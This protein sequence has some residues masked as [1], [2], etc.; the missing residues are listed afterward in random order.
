M[1]SRRLAFL[2][3]LALTAA[4]SS[5]GGYFG[6]YVGDGGTPTGDGGCPNPL[7]LCGG[8]CTS[9]QFDARNCGQCGNACATGQ[10]CIGGTCGSNPCTGAGQVPCGGGCVNPFTDPNNCGACGNP[11]QSGQ[12]CESGVCHSIGCASNR[13]CP[14]PS[15]GQCLVQCNG[16]CTNVFSDNLN[17]GNCGNVC[18]SGQTCQVG[19]CTPSNGCTGSGQMLC[20]GSCTNVFS[21]NLNCGNCGNVCQ[22]GTICQSGTCTPTNTCTGSG[23]ML[24]NGVCTNVLT[25]NFNCGFCGNACQTGT[26]CQSGS[27]VSTNPCPTGQVLCNGS[28]TDLLAD[29]NNCGSCNHACLTGQTCQNG[30]CINTT[31]MNGCNGAINCTNNNGQPCDQ[32]CVTN[33]KNTTTT[34]GWNLLLALINCLG[35]TCPSAQMTDPCSMTNPNFQ[36]AC[37]QCY[38]SAQAAGGACNAALT[39]CQMNTP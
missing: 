6:H 12:R 24:C 10:A 30:A 20:N 4:C 21:D 28:C 32:T 29:A 22:S 33:C 25:N 36:T 15:G 26:S 39:A 14:P 5:G 34:Q 2:L 27:C 19:A 11:C 38:A 1:R 13:N 37:M 3:P 9:T 17:C 35:T 8:A 23:M 16:T 31:P 7:V 18:P